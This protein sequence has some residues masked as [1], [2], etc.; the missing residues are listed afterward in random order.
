MELYIIFSKNIIKTY[1]A[2]EKSDVL[3]HT[4]INEQENVIA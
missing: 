4:L 1:S 2:T 3:C